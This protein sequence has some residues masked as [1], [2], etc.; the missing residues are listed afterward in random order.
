MWDEFLKSVPDDVQIPRPLWSME[1]G[2]T[3]AYEATTP[4]AWEDNGADPGRGAYGFPLAGLD[5][6]E[7]FARLPSHARRE[8]LVFP[9]WKIRF[10]KKNREFYAQNKDWLD[11]WIPKIRNFPSSWQKLEWNVGGGERDIWKYVVQMRAS[12]VRVK[13]TTTSPSLVA[14]T[15]TQVPIIAWENRYLTPR[16]GA[17]LQSLGAIELPV[18]KKSVYKALGNAVN[19]D[20]VAAIASPLLET[21]AGVSV[22][23]AVGELVA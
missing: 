22:T 7:R 12:G 23:A 14:M 20:V 16:E 5:R 18:A 10:I 4:F 9:D 11:K 2:A 15:P 17:R 13:N 8:Q 6:G 1:F 21:L 19:A 3:Y